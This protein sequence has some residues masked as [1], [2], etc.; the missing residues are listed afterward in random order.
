LNPGD[1]YLDSAQAMFNNN[2]SS[3]SAGA[4]CVALRFLISCSSGS[5]GADREP[6]VQ[7]LL[8]WGIH[9]YNSPPLEYTSP[10]R[11]RAWQKGGIR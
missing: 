1:G 7:N 2:Q 8:V 5:F 11:Q 4:I 9:I 6:T 3:C 10:T